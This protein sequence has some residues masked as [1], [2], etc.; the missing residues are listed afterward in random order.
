M[1]LAAILSMPIEPGMNTLVI[2]GI[3]LFFCGGVLD[4][5]FR[6]R[7]ARLG[8]KWVFLKGGTF[9]YKEYHQARRANGWP[10]WPVYLMWAAYICG[11]ALLVAGVLAQPV[12]HSQHG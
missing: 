7:M 9:N 1:S 2:C 8:Y 5:I 3:A 11:I 12:T 10:A 4:M 6:E